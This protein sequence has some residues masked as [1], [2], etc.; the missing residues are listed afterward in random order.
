[1]LGT[2]VF[3]MQRAVAADTS[4]RFAALDHV[5]FLVSDVEKSA[6]FYARVFGHT[7]LKNNRTTRRYVKLGAS[8]IA[9]DRS[10][11]GAV[12]VDHFCAGIPAFDVAAIHNYLEAQGVAYRDFPSGK[13]LA[14][15]DPD[16]TRLQLA[17]DNG[18]AQ[19]LGGTAS[20]ESTGG[21]SFRIAGG[22]V[23]IFRPTG[24]DHILLNVTDP[25]KSAAFYEKIL[26]PVTQRNNNRIW[27][28]VGTGRIGL[29]QTP[30][31]EKA[32]VNHY[33]VAVEKFD[34]DAAVRVLQIAGVKL[35]KAEIAGAPDLRDPDGYRV[36]VMGPR[37]Q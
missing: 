7:V 17:T 11:Q 13:D 31:G 26:G 2:G 30:A 16:G 9:M 10:A 33:C 24:I 20:P 21:G 1:M 32:G 22:A 34:Y 28:Q 35:D 8:Y 27:F 18:W 4:L 29:L 36:Q 6:A 15:T 25:E 5:E 12:N 14:V 19:L 23:P 37:A 3:A